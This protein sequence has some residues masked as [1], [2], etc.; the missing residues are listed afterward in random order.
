MKRTLNRVPFSSR[1]VFFQ[2]TEHCILS[3]SYPLRGNHDLPGAMAF[4]YEESTALE[5]KQA[6]VSLRSGLD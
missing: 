1:F 4:A 2:H 5:S 6:A 3:H